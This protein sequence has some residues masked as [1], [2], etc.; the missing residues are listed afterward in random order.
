M[1]L[2]QESVAR[3]E[4]SY[5]VQGYVAEGYGIVNMYMSEPLDGPAQVNVL[6]RRMDSV[7]RL[8]APAKEVEFDSISGDNPTAEI[9][10][11]LIREYNG[12]EPIGIRNDTPV[13]YWRTGNPPLRK[14][15]DPSVE[16]S[17]VPLP[18]N[19]IRG[20]G[21]FE[22]PVGPVHAG[23]IEP[24][25]FRFSVAGES[26]IKLNV[27]LGY[28]HRGVERLM[29]GPIVPGKIHIAERISGDTTVANSLAYSH[30]M[31]DDGSVPE[32]AGYIRV[33]AAE[34]ERLSSNISAVGG[35]CTDT[36]FSV[37]SARASKLH[38]D[39]LRMALKVFG[40]R[41]MH[42][43]VVPGGVR[44]D[45]SSEMSRY[46]ERS[47]IALKLDVLDLEDTM[48]TSSTLMDRMET[49]GILQPDIAKTYR[50][51]GPI[52]RASGMS[53]DVRK[54][55]PYDGY[56]HLGLLVP[57]ETGGDVL[58]R[59]KVRFREIYES[60]DLI[61]QSVALMDDGPIRADAGIPEGF[62][63]GI[64]EAP[65]G[66]LV[67]C[68]EIIDGKVW[69]YSIRDPSL[70]DWPMMSYAVPGNVVPDFPLINKS[71]SLSYSGNDL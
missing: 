1:I 67:H 49:T 65:R 8:T 26:V 15:R 25:H 66:E 38:E 12:Y 34:L 53:L 51:V 18:H 71:F 52:G 39:V 50:T 63:V 6:M 40:S 55:M 69:R 32:R 4:L 3:P 21:I 44:K 46:I 64:V 23:V 58:A 27:H 5:A 35:I 11:R 70:V 9:Y 45:I 20:D 47:L 60:I 41:Y 16:E 62:R 33:I 56:R 2:E 30:V 57:S 43:V 24:G 36:A 59:T 37:P 61:F 13:T 68:A 42:N 14:D 17:R 48:M 29:E 54:E 28:T 31:E 10:E 7:I 22:I 19:G